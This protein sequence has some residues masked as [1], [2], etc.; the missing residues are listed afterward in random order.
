MSSTD[1]SL[2]LIQ[3]RLKAARIE[4]G[5][6]LQKLAE[7]A[8][9]SK[10]TLQRYE[11]GFIRN[12]PLSKLD[13][14][15]QAL[16]VSGA[17]LLGWDDDVGEMQFEKLV[18]DAHSCDHALDGIMSADLKKRTKISSDKPWICKLKPDEAELLMT[19][20]LLS[21]INKGQIHNMVKYLKYQQDQENE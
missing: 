15:A 10:S 5:Y 4:K 3:Q 1:S 17:Y 20:S 16:G 12:L 11:S 6:S 14:L 13:T 2:N 7:I 21:D 19:Y 8:G 18:Q 9:M